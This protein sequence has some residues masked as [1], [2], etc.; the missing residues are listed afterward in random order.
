MAERHVHVYDVR[1]MAEPL[2]R[3]ES[4][5]KYQTRAIACMPDGEGKQEL[6][7]FYY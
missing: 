5:L 3:R 7:F 4:S 6:D 1:N 2:Q